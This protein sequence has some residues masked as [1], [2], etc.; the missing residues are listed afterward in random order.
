VSI[1][2]KLESYSRIELA[3]TAFYA[4]S[5]IILLLYLPLTGFA[6]QL[7]LL[8]VL[9]VIVAYG[10]YTR[11]KW[12]PWINFILFVG[13]STFAIYTVV[14]IGFSNVVIALEMIAYVVLTWFFAWYNIL[15]RT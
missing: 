8:G 12:T 2:S 7:G 13:A 3:S 9:S 11:R 6:P 1:A 4:I 5:G 10:V 14:S 15:K